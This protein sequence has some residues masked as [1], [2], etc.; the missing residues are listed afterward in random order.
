MPIALTLRRKDLLNKCI[1]VIDT[2]D[3]KRTT[4]DA[5]VTDAEVFKDKRIGDV[6]QKFIHQ[7]FYGCNRYQKFLK[8]FVTSF[9]Y[10][11]PTSAIRSDQ[12][13]YMVL[14]YL[15]FFRLGELGVSEFREFFSS[16][17]GTVSALLA[18]L[19]YALSQEDL[20]KWVKVEWCKVYDVGYI[21]DEIIGKLQ[22]Y[23]DEL[24]PLV[25]EVEF[26]TTGVCTMEKKT[27]TAPKPFNLTQ[28]RPRL[29][30]E[31]EVISREVKALPVPAMVNRTTLAEVEAEKRQRLEDEKT[32]VLE[33]YPATHHF[34]L[35]TA[36]RRDGTEIEELTRKVDAERMTE[37]TFKPKAAKKYAPPTEEAVVKQN[38]A[39]VLRED[40]LLRQK[41]AR[42]AE[43]L[44][45]YESEL[46]DA[47]DYNRW[48][49]D[50]KQKDHVEEE[51][52]VRKRM[53]EM[54]LAREGAIE[55]MESEVRKKN[56]RAQHQRVE[57]DEE[58]EWKQEE[59]KVDLQNKQ[60]LVA[61]TQEERINARIK[62]AEV[63]KG[64]AEHA[65]EI[66]KEKEAEF[67][68]KR[69]E[70]EQEME[71]RKDLIRQIRALE[72]VPVERFK[73]FDA[74]EPPCQ[75]LLEEMSLAELRERILIETSKRDKETEDKRE[76]QL[77]K[78][79]EKQNE[80]AEKAATLAKI[81]EQA[82][83]Q[84]E[85][86]HAAVKKRNI[87][88]EE[89]K[90]RHREQSIME[91]AEK[92]QLKKQQR[93]EEENKLKREL[94]EISTKRQFL[95]AN[96]EMVEAKAHGEQ[97]AGLDR[98]AHERQRITLV[99][100]RRRTEIKS[101]DN[102]IRRSNQQA[103]A[104]GY[105]AMQEAVNDRVRRAKAA[106]SALK[107]EILR[108]N[109]TA[110]KMTAEMGQTAHNKYI[111]RVNNAR[112]ASPAPRGGTGTSRMMVSA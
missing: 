75:G 57:L 48:Q 35:E 55:A 40:A 112:S 58:L 82:R 69:R 106:D 92:I 105:K 94:K 87:D 8:L 53:V 1:Q 108:C 86:K 61:E 28:P 26:K 15:L 85:S 18:L 67:E 65:E 32:R 71:K 83:E 66:R 97:H 20:E 59:Y 93:K 42:E 17:L 76:R 16:G 9:M 104:D 44:K 43:I 19:Q 63:L 91:V 107:E 46:H 98:E 96:A 39:A 95:S 14:G 80:F 37:C 56:I 50:M 101:K 7:V 12:T 49:Q 72:K 52:R 5:Y 88:I 54:Q 13:L 99:E 79:V 11:C 68:R 22:T 27:K 109:S 6:E 3:P 45:N 38:V 29:I 10:K 47:S 84:Q 64:R 110:R 36:N 34:N 78:K 25:E 73:K 30:P 51:T 74:A 77:E 31:P 24:R 4:V 103:N 23:S 89:A 81:R 41:Q 102:V 111:S 60:L 21:E 33:K 90:A 100:S 70:D 62:E 2:F